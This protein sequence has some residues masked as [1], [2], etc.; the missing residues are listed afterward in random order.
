MVRLEFRG[1]V[2]GALVCSSTQPERTGQDAVI[3]VL[4]GKTTYVHREYKNPPKQNAATAIST[5]NSVNMARSARTRRLFEKVTK[6]SL[7]SE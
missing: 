2:M 7:V 6:A 4:S 5:A 3:K 1:V